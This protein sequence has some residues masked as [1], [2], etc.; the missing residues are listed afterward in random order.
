MTSLL[1]DSKPKCHRDQPGP[2]NEIIYIEQIYQTL[3]YCYLT[4][5][6][7]RILILTFDKIQKA[8]FN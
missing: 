3:T 8:R 5:K 4:Q 7:L 6:L 1:D 2:S